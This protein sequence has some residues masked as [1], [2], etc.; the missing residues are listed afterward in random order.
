[1]KNN[2]DFIIDAVI[3]PWILRFSQISAVIFFILSWFYV[4]PKYAK[5]VAEWLYISDSQL[6]IGMGCLEVKS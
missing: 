2:A 6:G 4:V 3:L 1:M 5:Q